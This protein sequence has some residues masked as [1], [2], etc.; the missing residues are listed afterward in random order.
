MKNDVTNLQ[1][2]YNDYNKATMIYDSVLDHIQINERDNIAK[3][4][5]VLSK[6]K[7]G[8][9][10]AISLLCKSFLMN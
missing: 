1:S 8:Y 9:E 6:K 10:F 5:E 4:I 7:K 2:V 3:L